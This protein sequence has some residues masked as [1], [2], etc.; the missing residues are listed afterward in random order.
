MH[1]KEDRKRYFTEMDNLLY[2]A[3]NEFK[4]F[5]KNSPKFKINIKKTKIVEDF[6]HSGDWMKGR[7]KCSIKAI[8]EM[9]TSD[10][11]FLSNHS[12]FPIGTIS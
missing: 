11:S 12:F 4:A 2:K 6:Y 3:K 1:N 10:F 9:N 8:K 5:K 7:E